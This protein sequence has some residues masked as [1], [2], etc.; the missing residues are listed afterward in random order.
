MNR[1]K[2]TVETVRARPPAGQW[3]VAEVDDG[4]IV[5][6]GEAVLYSVNSGRP[7]KFRSLDTVVKKLR[8]EIGIT[9]FEVV[10]MNITA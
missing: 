9:E 5:R 3:I 4:Y 10:V 2:L 8:E 6:C 1:E 7:R